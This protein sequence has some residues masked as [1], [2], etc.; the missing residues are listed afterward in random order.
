MKRERQ[1]MN[2]DDGHLRRSSSPTS[3]ECQWS[4]HPPIAVGKGEGSTRMMMMMMVMMVI[5]MR[6]RR[7]RRRWR[8]RW[9]GR[10]WLE[11]FSQPL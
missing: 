5:M 2:D 3:P 11:V 6:R 1:S 4:R 7:R 10:S 9:R 8:R